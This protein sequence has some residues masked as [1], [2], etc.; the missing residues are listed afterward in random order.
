MIREL[1]KK[2]RGKTDDEF[3]KLING[4]VQ[5]VV[6]ICDHL[7]GFFQHPFLFHAMSGL[8]RRGIKGE[9]VGADGKERTPLLISQSSAL[10]ATNLSSLSF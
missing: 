3:P 4:G 7:F 6:G 9:G 1:S 10:L 2:A 8:H 5:T